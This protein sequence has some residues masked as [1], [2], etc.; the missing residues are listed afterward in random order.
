MKTRA[1]LMNIA[2]MTAAEVMG[3]LCTFELPSRNNPRPKTYL[4]KCPR[5]LAETLEKGELVLCEYESQQASNRDRPLTSALVH[6]VLDAFDP[7]DMSMP[8]RWV[9][10]RVNKDRLTSL[11]AWENNM[12]DTLVASQRRKAREAVLREVVGEVAS[13]P[14]FPSLAAPINATQGGQ[15][16]A[17]DDRTSAEEVIEQKV[18]RPNSLRSKTRLAA[19]EMD[20]GFMGSARDIAEGKDD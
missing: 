14:S 4:Y 10:D 3:V 19:H 18:F 6:E 7:E 15:A 2:C 1:G 11:R 17:Q 9:F 5:D 13:R 12:T 20:E 16:V 8:H